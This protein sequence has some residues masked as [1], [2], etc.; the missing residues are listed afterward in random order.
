M[1]VVTITC[2]DVPHLMVVAT[3][4]AVGFIYLRRYYLNA[5]RELRRLEAAGTYNMMLATGIFC[6]NFR[7]ISFLIV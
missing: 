6:N 2:L 4:L 7:K 1:A 3:L 5:S